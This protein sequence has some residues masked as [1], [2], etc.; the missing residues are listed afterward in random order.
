MS[1]SPDQ[2]AVLDDLATRKSANFWSSVSGIDLRKAAP[3]ASLE[4]KKR[5]VESLCPEF[6]VKVN[7]NLKDQYGITLTG[8][9]ASSQGEA[10]RR[11]FRLVLRLLHDKY[12]AEGA[13]RYY[14]WRELRERAD[15]ADTKPPALVD[16][17]ID[18]G[19]LANAKFSDQG[20]DI[21]Q[22]NR[23]D[24][25][26]LL[27]DVDDVDELLALRKKQADAE[28][29]A[30]EDKLNVNF[31]AR[32]ILQVFGQRYE[33]HGKRDFWPAGSWRSSSAAPLLPESPSRRR[34][35]WRRRIPGPA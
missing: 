21:V 26:E 20:D 4:E 24:D 2:Q 6:A 31:L 15:S 22:W 27:R 23:P 1:L 19:K 8:L 10:V 29:Q 28:A 11:W 30:A 3:G 14:T 9:L 34:C 33:A 18:L 13:F 7:S 17:V 16:A 12:D 5:I 25:I 32:R 35:W